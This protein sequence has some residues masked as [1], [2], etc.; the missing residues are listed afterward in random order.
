MIA[1]K[2]GA[3]GAVLKIEKIANSG[4]GTESEVAALHGDLAKFYESDLKRTNDE[5][6]PGS[7]FAGVLSALCEVALRSVSG[8]ILTEADRRT[9]NVCSLALLDVIRR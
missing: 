1:D 8:T 7:S 5:I 9:V 4:F 3:L 2:Q 6:D